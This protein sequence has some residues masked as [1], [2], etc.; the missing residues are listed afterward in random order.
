MNKFDESHSGRDEVH[1]IP[2]AHGHGMLDQKRV[3]G[4]RSPITMGVPTVSAGNA[5]GSDGS[6]SPGM[7][8]GMYQPMDQT[9]S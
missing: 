9:G 8:N 4:M 1:E 2:R 7:P 5:P 6:G 3:K